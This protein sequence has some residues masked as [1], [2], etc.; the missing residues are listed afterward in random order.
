MPKYPY[1]SWSAPKSRT[2]VWLS[3]QIPS[4][5]SGGLDRSSFVKRGGSCSGGCLKGKNIW[6]CSQDS[7]LGTPSEQ[8]S[9]EVQLSAS[10]CVRA[11]AE[12]GEVPD[13]FIHERLPHL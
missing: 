11:N 9:E 3:S 12:A 6:L 10:A 13:L 2:L 1:S 8:V 7:P 5:V 4:S